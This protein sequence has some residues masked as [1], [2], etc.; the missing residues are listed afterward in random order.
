[1]EMGQC[2]N[3]ENLSALETWEIRW[4]IQELESALPSVTSEAISRSSLCLG[5]STAATKSLIA[6]V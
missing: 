4:W 6:C 1:M 2:P 5:F 3:L